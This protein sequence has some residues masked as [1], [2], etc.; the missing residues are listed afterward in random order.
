MLYIEKALKSLNDNFPNNWLAPYNFSSVEEVDKS[1]TELT[2]I[3]S[4]AASEF[5][6]NLNLSV[7]EGEYVKYD[8][9]TKESIRKIDTELKK[10]SDTEV[11]DDSTGEILSQL[12]YVVTI[13]FVQPGISSLKKYTSLL[14]TVN[15]RLNKYNDTPTLLDI[16]RDDKKF[17][18]FPSIDNVTTGKYYKIFED[19]VSL[20][21]IDHDLKVSKTILQRLLLIS[22]SL[23][24]TELK[25]FYISYLK[26][27]SDFLIFKIYYRYKQN[28]ERY[29]Y[30]IDFIDREIRTEEILTP[31]FKDFREIAECHYESGQ[32]N[33]HFFRKRTEDFLEKRDRHED[34]TF[35]EYHAVIKYYKD[36]KKSLERLQ[37]HKTDFS[38]LYEKKAKRESLFN[39]RAF[40]IAKSYLFN[41]LYSLKI[42]KGEIDLLNWEPEF[43]AITQL[44]EDLLINNYFPY[45]K[46]LKFLDRTIDALFQAEEIEFDDIERLIKRYRE[47]LFEF[48]KKIDWCEERSFLAYQLPFEECIV[49]VEIPVTVT[50]E[51]MKVN[52]FLSSSFVL[53]LNFEILQKEV[54][55]FN[56][57][58]LKYQTML[59]IQQNI[60]KDKAEIKDLRKTMDNTDKRSIE[61]LSIFSAIV[62]FVAGDIQLFTKIDNA[63]DAISF[64][65]FFGYILGSF[66]LLIWFITRADGFRFRPF[67]RLH[68][69]IILLFISGAIVG[70]GMLRGWFNTDEVNEQSK[71]IEQLNYKIDTLQKRIQIIKLENQIQKDST[72]K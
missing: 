71:E 13:N 64:M 47:L 21:R 24:K 48:N 30:A 46:T 50:N 39:K 14:T 69:F 5:Y 2:S 15:R 42:D 34:G 70:F 11:D 26:Q 12:Y 22:D 1:I 28:K 20:A 55:E 3:V 51:V 68:I 61:I 29:L 32:L 44:Q 59:D 43:Q 40:D 60:K 6:L 33:T 37:N 65:F 31:Y 49:N 67:S 54:Q 66:V 53:P 17:K 19:N 41:N 38:S 7:I 52:G 10:I 57:R 9:E 36:E 27:K 18:N 45:E 25:D 72:A 56:A 4:R 16:F 8:I 35:C 63:S 58:L 23:E 62:L